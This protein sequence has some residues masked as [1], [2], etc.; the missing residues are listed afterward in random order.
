LFDVAVPIGDHV[1]AAQM[2]VQRVVVTAFAIRLQ[3][4]HE[5]AADVAL[6][7]GDGG[8]AQHHLDATDIVRDLRR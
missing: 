4:D 8:A 5:E 3:R 2:I 6:A 7:L 1:R